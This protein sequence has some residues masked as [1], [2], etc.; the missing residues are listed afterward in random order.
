[1]NIKILSM[2]IGI[3]VVTTII[4]LY[5]AFKNPAFR[6]G[7]INPLFLVTELSGLLILVNIFAVVIFA[8]LLHNYIGYRKAFL[9]TAVV[10]Y[11]S[12]AHLYGAYS[13]I[14]STNEYLSDPEGYTKMVE[15]MTKSSKLSQYFSIIILLMFIPIFIS[16]LAFDLALRLADGR[17]NRR[18]KAIKKMKELL[19]K[20]D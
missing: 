16:Y 8:Y 4:D 19:E 15:G 10:L 7:E 20:I 9:F 13:N 3:F 1:M 17:L 11:A 12:M 6:I 18:Q 5:T 14:V 2:L